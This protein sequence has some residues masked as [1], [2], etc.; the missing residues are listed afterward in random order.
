LPHEIEMSLSSAAVPSTAHENPASPGPVGERDW[1]GQARELVDDLG[2]RKPLL[3]WADFLLSISAAWLLTGVYFAAAAWS[4]LQLVSFLLAGI[5][6]YRAGTF[7]H[8]IAHMGREEMRGFKFAWNALLGIPLLMPWVLYRNHVGHHSVQDF[9]TPRDGEYTPLASSPLSEFVKYLAEIPLLPLLVVARFGVLGP[10]SWL[11]PRWR[12][13]VL[14]RATAYASNPYYRKRFPD[15]KRSHMLM[16]ELLCFAWL[17]ALVS[18]TLFGPMTGTH[19]LMAWG[20]LTWTLGLNWV[21]NLAAH[22]YSNRGDRLTRA[23]QVEESVNLVGQTWLTVWMFP[24]GLRYHAL[25]HL[26]PHL[27]YHNLGIAHRRLVENL[28]ADAGYHRANH[29]SYFALVS[30]LV[31]GARAT[32]RADSAMRRWQ[33]QA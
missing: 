33:T 5:A 17:L 2:K 30:R 13:W 32:A 14:T 27:P 10:V 20:L 11:H 22:T 15:N 4:A 21:R 3:Y 6:F 19:W 31:R 23:A 8:E 16:V 7:I 12:E 29:H 9:G 26:F 25:H 28:P 24:V 1:L 18:L